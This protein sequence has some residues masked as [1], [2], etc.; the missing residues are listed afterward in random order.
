MFDIKHDVKYNKV[1]HDMKN[2]EQAPGLSVLQ[3]GYDV[4]EFYTD[5]YNHLIRGE[6]LQKQWKLPNWID[7]FRN[8]KSILL[9]KSITN[10]YQIYHDCGKPYVLTIDD[11][12]NR[13]FE[14]HAEKSYHVWLEEMDGNLDVAELIKRDMDIHI[15]KNDDVKSF[16]ESKYAATLLLTGL[17]EIHANSKMFGGFDSLSFKIKWKHLNRRGNAIVKLLK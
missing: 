8:N 15:L 13:H 17:S 4:L 7:H 14:N 2:C 5:I 16:C 9:D 3:H 6:Q 12:G 1:I 11:N 10:E